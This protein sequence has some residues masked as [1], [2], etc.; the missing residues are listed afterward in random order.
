MGGRGGS[1][2]FWQNDV[3]DASDYK[4]ESIPMLKG[5]PKQIEW[6]NE[7]R[8]PMLK[9]LANY[10]V[11]RTSDGRASMLYET[12]RKGKGAIINDIQSSPLVKS[13]SGALKKQKIKDQVEGYKDLAGR[14]KRFNQIVRN[15]SA[16]F[17]I[18]N[19]TNQPE[20]YMNQKLKRRIDG[21]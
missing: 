3:P 14:I 12:A 17:W 7:I 11:R 20:N 13:T 8:K 10:T 9:E 19:R 5:T 21:K 4:A 2:G 1:S 15:D 18:D 16:K 6:A